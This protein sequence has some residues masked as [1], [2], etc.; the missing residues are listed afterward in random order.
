MKHFGLITTL[1][2]TLASFNA[3]AQTAR[4]YSSSDGLANS[5]I[6]DI[7]QD[8]KGFIWISTE[9]GLSR[10]DGL[11][12][13]NTSFDRSETN[14]I[15]SNTVR[16]VLEDSKG[17][18]WVGTSAGLQT[19]NTD[20]NTYTKINL[21]DWGVPDSDQHI[22][23][24]MELTIGEE[25]K[26]LAASSGHGIYIL[27]ADSCAIDHDSQNAINRS[28]PSK[29]ISTIF[30]DSS[31]MLWITTEAGGISLIDL[32]DFS[33]EPVIW[34]RSLAI[35]S[36]D[37][38]NTFAEDSQAGNILIGTQSYGMLVWD[39][40][41]GQ[42]RRPKGKSNG[43]SS[44]MSIIPNNIAT[45]YGEHTFLVGIENQG[46]KLYNADSES[47]SG[48]RFSNVPFNTSG[49]KVHKLMEDS[50]GNVWVGALQNGVMIIP[51][52]MFGFRHVDLGPHDYS[53]GRN[54]SVTSVISDEE[55]D[56][57]WVGTDGSGI[58]R[59]DRSNSSDM[60][61]SA[62]NSG[63]SN[64]SIMSLALDSR[65]TLWIAT[66]L[67]GLFTYSPEK[68]VR[69]FKDQKSIG[70]DKI[71]N[72]A[73]S[74]EEDA[75][76]VGTHGNGLSK[77]DA[78]AEKVMQTW[79]D[80]SNKWISYL[81]FDSSGLLWIG[82]YN[83]PK[84]YDSR[85]N[86]LTGY[87]LIE[88]K[89]IRVNSIFETKDGNIWIGTGE[90]LICMDRTTKERTLYTED[91][92][93]ACNPVSSI[94]EDEDGHLWISTL[95][96]LSRFH[97]ETKTFKN[98]F[99]YDGLQENEFNAK[100]AYKRPNGRMYFGGINGLT[101]FN[102][103][104]VDNREKNIPSLYLSG[105]SIMNK[106]VRYDPANGENNI[107]DKHISEAT[108]ITLPNDADIFSVEFS[109]LEYTNP[110]KVVYEYMMEGLEKSWNRTFNDSNN[111]TYTNLPSGRYKLKIMAFYEGEPEE[112]SYR[113]IDV[114]VLHPWY[115]S[116]WA[117]LI[118]ISVGI[119]IV[120]TLLELRNRRIALKAQQEESEIKE[121]KLEMFTNISHE[122][123]TPLTLVM[124]P[125]KQ[126]RENE[127]EPR[128]KDL[129]NLMYRNCLRI[130]R[131]V[132]Q[133]LDMRKVDNGQMKLHFVET[134]VIYFIKD[135]MKSFDNLA[136]SK[137]IDFSLNCKEE[138]V[139]LWI[140]H[141]NFDKVIFNILSNA[142]KY[143]PDHGRLH[144]D[145]SSKGECVEF[146]I[147]N[148]GDHI[149]EKHIDK[150]FDRFYQA[151][152]RDAKMGSGVGLHLAK[153]LVEL[154][155]GQISVFNTEDGVAFRIVLPVG[156]GH[157]SEEERTKP[158]NHKDL[159]TKNIDATEEHSSAEDVTYNADKESNDQVKQ[160]K[161]RKRIVLVDDDSEM[162]AYLKLE[163][164]NIYNVEV[165][166][167]GKDAWARIS[168]SV[169]DAVI[170]DLIM[171][172][173]D[174]AELCSKIKKNPGTNHIPVILL[175]SSSDESSQ[176]RCIDS[177]AD[178][179]FT[180][181]ISLD[182][183]KSAIAGAI[184]TRETIKNKYSRDI[185]YGYSELKITNSDSQL[186][187]KVIGI[188][189]KNIEN[190][191]FSVEELSREVGMSRVHLNRKLKETMNISP[192]NLIRSIRLKQAAY[193]LIFN[194]VNISEVAYKVGFS[195][196]SYFSNSFH[197]FF[198]MTPKE[199]TAKYMNCTDEETLKNLFG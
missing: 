61:L 63:L 137:K 193:L 46:I 160:H 122:I 62:E 91:D 72:L 148:T 195:T 165:F 133:L 143:T 75:L 70:T 175:T 115:M 92:G 71:Y 28:L 85:V 176:Q 40:A 90:G 10:F 55:R 43:N 24:L 76:Y 169:P 194:K 104:Y 30:K 184:T 132:N 110:Q 189:R 95:N 142:F 18:F 153:M 44:I 174:G 50:Q 4:L 147:E 99:Q 83:G 139:N 53:E 134:D 20:Y 128:Q 149:G 173:M 81:T 34:N 111:A 68:G 192:S 164:Q 125:L 197:D 167:N 78:K 151:D 98:F 97:L 136:T 8:S 73:Y 124:T 141:G 41:T 161:T 177:G 190:S 196:H 48:V 96:G 158:Q 37:I 108:R 182:I 69:Q 138:S 186:A 106:E 56:I 1:I 178:R 19:F 23:K 26:I 16:T 172:K 74:A 31:N 157:L 13:L 22:T 38:I 93:L 126:M 183:L 33:S 103:H 66:Y 82:T 35:E 51:K 58:Y 156:C 144:I 155:H 65:G 119:I 17:R 116:L 64:N 166:A 105:I 170:T 21:E 150:V 181:P 112:F 113:E 102:P 140:D 67:G 3:Q 2:I 79:D 163:L 59:T 88:G 15:A 107:L 54:I 168:T 130:L 45:R 145:V 9:N 188:I 32:A 39:K 180:K 127:N 6:H 5:H 154:H 120:L 100:A 77:V 185:D 80:D 60:N 27:D 7:F 84:A 25:R 101:V 87:E 123:R 159:Y 191:D 86:S 129:Y 52:S 89:S 29:F 135:I 171:E 36:G 117:W 12:F 162:R 187:S 14:S 114:K 199:F 118:Y 198:G 109:V 57:L 146:T 49:W 131:I 11:R 152:I 179:F 94:L 121:M 42:I 47:I